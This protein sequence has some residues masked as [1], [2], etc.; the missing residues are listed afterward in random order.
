MSAQPP[1]RVLHFADLHLGVET[2]GRL[3]PETGL[4]RRVRDF[5]DRLAEIVKYAIQHEA[6]VVIFAGDAFKTR[7]PNATL[8]RAFARHI[9]ALSRAG[10]HTVLLAG[11]HDMPLIETR[12]T[13]LDI[14]GVLEVPYVTV[15]L[16]ERVHRIQTPRGLLQVA[17]VPWPQRARLLRHEEHRSRAPEELD[18]LLEQIIAQEIERLASELDP[19][20]PAILVAHFS[21]SGAR[22]GTE[23]NVLLGSDVIFKLSSLHLSAWDYVALG[24][25]HSHQDLNPGRYPAVVYAG[26]PERVD[27]SEA[28]EQKGF[29]WVEVAKGATQW[30]FVPLPARAMVSVDLD[31]TEQA[32]PTDAAL[33]A[34]ERHPVKDAIVRVRLRL[35]RDQESLLDVQRIEQALRQ[36]GAEYVAGIHYELQAAPRSRLGLERPEQLSPEE[37]LRRYFRSK[38]EDEQRIE[39]LM[40]LARELMQ[41]VAASA[42]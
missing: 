32:D 17:T 30:R 11:N 7:D 23:R 40:A 22:F 36:A 29:C 5:A 3:D 35:R 33:R 31:L 16:D 28:D 12:A 15:A 24:H 37:L 34:L 1:I 18:A 25:I 19:H 9:R 20:A 4:S 2:Y 21:V 41:P 27:F 8:Q 26:S 6:D 38:G 13:S 10:I 14:F 42:R 39:A